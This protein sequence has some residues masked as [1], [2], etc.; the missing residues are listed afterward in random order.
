MSFWRI[1]F[2]HTHKERWNK[3]ELLFSQNYR[4]HSL[5]I[6]IFTSRERYLVWRYHRQGRT[7]E[8]CFC[9]SVVT[10]RISICINP[11]SSNHSPRPSTEFLWQ[12]RWP[13]FTVEWG[14]IKFLK[15]II[16]LMQQHYTSS[17]LLFLSKEVP[18]HCVL[19]I[20][21]LPIC[22]ALEVRKSQCLVFYCHS[23]NIKNIFLIVC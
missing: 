13:I 2:F 16:A 4:Q 17:Y 15:E 6:F 20:F 10:T 23:G 1:F 19:L 22:S 9:I 11:C 5:K 7:K 18:I 3:K 14:E 8:I 12:R 21:A